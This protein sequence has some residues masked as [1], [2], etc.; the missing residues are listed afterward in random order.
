MIGIRPYDTY[1][2]VLVL[3]FENFE[4]VDGYYSYYCGICLCIFSSC[5]DACS[6]RIHLIWV[7]FSSD[8]LPCLGFSTCFSRFFTFLFKSLLQKTQKKSIYFSFHFLCGFVFC[9]RYFCVNFFLKNVSFGKE[10][11]FFIHVGFFD[12]LIRIQ[13][14]KECKILGSILKVMINYSVKGQKRRAIRE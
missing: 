3:V 10:I 1:K 14:Y 8:Q 13:R 5:V 6:K 11:N 7:F 12:F 2:M 9:W 4:C